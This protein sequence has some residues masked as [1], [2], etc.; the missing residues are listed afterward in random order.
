[1]LDLFCFLVGQDAGNDLRGWNADFGANG[2]RGGRIVA[3]K[4]P[5]EDAA[6]LEG[7]DGVVCFGAK[8]VCYGE[9]SS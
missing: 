5:D 1:M 4:H 7:G 2:A 6:G 9:D 3:G 8:G